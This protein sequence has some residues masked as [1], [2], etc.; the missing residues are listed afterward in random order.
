MVFAPLD[1]SVFLAISK[2]I[3][4]I[5]DKDVFSPDI[6]NDCT[7][8]D[9]ASLMKRW[10][11]ELTMCIIPDSVLPQF[12][13]A[14]SNSTFNDFVEILPQVNK[15]TLLYL[16]GFLQVCLKNVEYT[17][18]NSD[19][20]ATVFAPNIAGTNENDTLIVSRINAQAKDFIDHMIHHFNAD[21]YYPLDQKYFEK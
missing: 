17:K 21:E 18:M 19:A 11:R 10:L 2:K 14:I 20:L 15:F 4:G 6:F 9:L 12:E 8:N 16:I 7:I 13:E 5:I 3:D 1:F